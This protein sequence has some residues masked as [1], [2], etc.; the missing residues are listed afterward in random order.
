MFWVYKCNSKGWDYQRT[1]GD[2]AD[3]FA[4]RNAKRWGSTEWVP[5]LDQARGGDTVIAYQTDR[6]ELVGVARVVKWQRR[7][8]FKDLI[9]KP[10]QTIG[11]RVR[12]LKAANP[13]VARIPA[14]QPGPIQ[15]LYR[16]AKG[17]ALTLLKAAGI[18]LRLT[19]NE[20]EGQTERA[21]HGAGFGTP[22]QNKRVERAAL[23]HVIRYLR[24]RRWS[25]QDVSSENRGYDLFCSRRKEE[26]H[27]EVKG[28]RGD[29]QQFPL[30]ARE[31]HTW[32][33]DQRFTLAF[34]GNALS[35][36]P[37]LSLFPG[38][39]ARTEFEFRPLSYIVTRRLRRTAPR[40]RAASVS[41]SQK[42]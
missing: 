29:G 34:V 13:K 11:V 7:G 32:S 22:E 31:L 8:R 35:G 27:V 41:P 19:V 17:D 33:N 28:A 30:T 3:V 37:L 24:A 25:V 2:W 38:P 9:L 12:P 20:S 39:E 4:T 36:S 15:T 40:G 23:R 14:L 18:R 6:N 1:D 26:L 10:G 16:I 42:V 5:K 21:P